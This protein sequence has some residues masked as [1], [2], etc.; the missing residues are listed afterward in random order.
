L[1]LSNEV[2]SVMTQ[3]EQQQG[4]ELDTERLD[5]TFEAVKNSV[6]NSKKTQHF[7][8]TIISWLMMFKEIIAVYS[9]YDTSKYTL[10]AKCSCWMQKHVV[11]TVTTMP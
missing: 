10:W 8:I 7:T 3:L 9:S 6:S 1:P 11:H 4:E 5:W 2:D